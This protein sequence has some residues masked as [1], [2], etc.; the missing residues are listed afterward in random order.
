M[1]LLAKGDGNNPS[2]SEV[3]YDLADHF[4][5]KTWTCSLFSPINTA[6]FLYF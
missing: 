2:L 5:E 6:F 3:L 1:Q 4:T